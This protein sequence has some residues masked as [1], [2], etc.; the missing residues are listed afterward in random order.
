MVNVKANSKGQPQNLTFTCSRNHMKSYLR[1]LGETYK[2]Q[3][4]LIKQENNHK[5]SYEDTW[6]SKRSE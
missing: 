5:E 2:L 1:K 4:S 6:E 3:P